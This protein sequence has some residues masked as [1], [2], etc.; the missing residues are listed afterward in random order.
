MRGGGGSRPVRRGGEVGPRRRGAGTHPIPRLC[1]VAANAMNGSRSAREGAPTPGLGSWSHRPCRHHL[2][3]GGFQPPDP[4]HSGPHGIEQ[5]LECPPLGRMGEGLPVQPAQVQA[6]PGRAALVTAPV[7]QQEGR[8][9]LALAA[10][11]LD[12]HR[13]GAH[14]V[15]RGNAGTVARLGVVAFWRSITS[16]GQSSSATAFAF[17]YRQAAASRRS[18][19]KPKS[20]K[21]SECPSVWFSG[22][23]FSRSRM[24]RPPI[25]RRSPALRSKA[26]SLANT[27]SIGWSSSMRPA[28]RRT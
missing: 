8:D 28:P 22:L 20:K 25:V 16:P 13:P 4:L 27:C 10:V 18:G 23:K 15:P 6:F 26:L 7:P 17:K 5:F 3:Q 24:L 21:H 1:G 2:E 12:R 9:V 11:V 14:Q 19:S